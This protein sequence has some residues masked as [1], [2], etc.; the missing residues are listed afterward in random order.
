[1]ARDGD[2]DPGE[3]DAE[4]EAVREKF[5]HWLPIV[6]AY[7]ALV[8]LHSLVETQLL[9]YAKRLRKQ[10]GLQLD[11]SDI[12]GQGVAALK[13]YFT[14]AAAVPIGQDLGWQELKNLQDLRNIIVHRRGQQGPDVRQQQNVQRLV[15]E[16]SSDL[17]LTEGVSLESRELLVSFRLCHHFVDQV[18]QF[19]VRFCRAAG[20]Q[21]RGFQ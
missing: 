10:R 3:H 18:E 1:M 15:A 17:S 11:V 9:A 8:L 19:F 6:S 5:G 20:F 12:K 21:E 2:W 13:T 4:L 14:K 7:S 16:Y